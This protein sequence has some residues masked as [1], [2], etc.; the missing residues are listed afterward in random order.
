M[1]PLAKQLTYAL[2]IPSHISPLL[3]RCQVSISAHQLVEKLCRW[4]HFC[5]VQCGL[6][7][8]YSDVS[9]WASLHLLC[10]RDVLIKM[11]DNKSPFIPGLSSL[12]QRWGDGDEPGE[13]TTA[14]TGFL[15]KNNTVFHVLFVFLLL[16]VES[17]GVWFYFNFFKNMYI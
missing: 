12:Q 14:T 13:W 4:K 1:L 3:I 5:F 8:R 2:V 7:A 10:A 17:G 9:R 15:K 6:D 16:V 11:A